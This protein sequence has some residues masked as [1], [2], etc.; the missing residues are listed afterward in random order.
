MIYIALGLA[1]VLGY[2]IWALACELAADW[3][4]RSI[5]GKVG[6]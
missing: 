6:R 5:G 1:V 2:G 3:V 4:F